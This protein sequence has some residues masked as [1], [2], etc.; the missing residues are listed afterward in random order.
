MNNF[1]GNLFLFSGKKRTIVVFVWHSRLNRIDCTGKI[2]IIIEITTI[3]A[4][5]P[6]FGETIPKI[7]LDF[8]V[9]FLIFQGA[10]ANRTEIEIK[11]FLLS[12]K[13]KG[14]EKGKGGQGDKETRRQGEYLSSSP[15]SLTPCP[16]ELASRAFQLG[17]FGRGHQ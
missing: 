9:D 15:A 17:G 3:A 8:P 6:T 10:T 7:P 1:H 13:K 5:M 4:T 16:K 14:R 12:P 2:G 11:H